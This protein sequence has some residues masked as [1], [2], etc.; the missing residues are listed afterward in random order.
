MSGIRGFRTVRFWVAAL[1]TTP[2]PHLPR[3]PA[4]AGISGIR[5]TATVYTGC[6]ACRSSYPV[7]FGEAVAAIRR[8]PV[9]GY[10]SVR[11]T[12]LFLF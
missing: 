11:K 1:R 7:R 5:R 9:P 2:L 8:R 6:T 3:D 12:S 10:G 4:F